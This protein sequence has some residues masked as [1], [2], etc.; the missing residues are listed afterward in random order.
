M[1]DRDK[2]C[3][4]PPHVLE[5]PPSLLQ[6]L[7]LQS[8]RKPPLGVEVPVDVDVD[9]LVEVLVDVL[10]EVLVDVDVDVD[11]DVEEVAP[12]EEV[13][14]ET[15]VPV[16]EEKVQACVLHACVFSCSEAAGHA[17]PPHDAGVNTAR[18]NV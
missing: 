1:I 3:L 14:E 5:Q 15:L 4:P 13:V 10:V 2:V 16:E 8:T 17:A 7:S 6:P 11:V 18:L 12:P 9:V